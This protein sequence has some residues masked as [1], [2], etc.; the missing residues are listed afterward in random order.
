VWSKHTS[1]SDQVFSTQ[2]I[3]QQADPHSWR[4]HRFGLPQPRWDRLK[5]CAY[6]VTG[7]G[8]GYGRAIALV[9]A[10]AGAQ[11]FLT[12]RRKEKLQETLDEG[13]ALGIGVDRCVPVV[14]DISEEPDLVR[15]AEKISRYVSRLHGL[16]NNAALPQPDV[17]PYPLA[18]QSLAAWSSLFATNVTAQWLTSRVALPLM[19][20]GEG[21][22]IIFMSSEAGWASTPGF[23]PY[24]ISKSAVNTLGASLAAECSAHFPAHDVQINV[25]V[26][27]EARTEMNH[28]STESPYSV[29]SMILTLLSHPRGGPN[30]H[31]FH[32]DGRHLAFGYSSAYT[33]DLLA[34]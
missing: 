8:T 7:A 6:W 18:Q 14:A 32:R 5:G 21:I 11:V 16:V 19:E 20:D 3:L 28:G 12:G 10:A 13:V 9:L 4:D 27:G 33:K 31:F 2:G 24:N 23:G 34:R 25:L 29:A 1:S 26:P 17:A 22:R 15:A 30:G